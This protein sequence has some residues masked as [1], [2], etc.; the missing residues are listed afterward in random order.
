MSRSIVVIKQSRTTGLSDKSISFPPFHNLHLELMEVKKKLKKNL[1]P[2]KIQ[3]IKQAPVK[4]PTPPP[5]DIDVGGEEMPDVVDDAATTDDGD[6]DMIDELGGEEGETET[7]GVDDGEPEPDV[8]QNPDDLLS[9]EE[10]EAKEKEEFIWRFKILKKQY[11]TRNIQDYNEHDDIQLMKTSYERTIR[12]IHLE[13]SVES[14]RMYLIGGF[15][16]TEFICC[17]W[18][19]IDMKGFANQQ[20]NMM[21]RYDR[22]LIELGE[23]SYSRWGLNLPVEI[24]LIGFII[25]QA[26]IFY[27]GKLLMSSGG[28]NMSALFNAMA[29][30]PAPAQTS[31]AG[32]QEEGPRMKGPSV[33]ISE[34]EK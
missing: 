27:V 30:G 17:N 9:P 22:L 21:D 4:P 33:K 11:P 28:G 6:A 26:G 29:G 19:G 5:E 23:R 13:T 2:V 8:P 15:M 34:K 18:M 7:E 12:E 10:R 1:P 32:A 31:A 20:K 14:Y 25:I 24:R 16:A 3:P